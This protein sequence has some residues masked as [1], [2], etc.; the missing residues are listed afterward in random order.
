M[1]ARLAFVSCFC[2]IAV[3]FAV[4]DDS[5]AGQLDGA[6]TTQKT[7]NA[8]KKFSVEELLTNTFPKKTSNDTGLNPCKADVFVDDIAITFPDPKRKLYARYVHQDLEETNKHVLYTENVRKLLEKKKIWKLQEATSVPPHKIRKRAAVTTFKE[9][10]WDHGVIPYEIDDTFSDYRKALAKQAMRHWENNTCLK[11]IERNKTENENYVFFTEKPCG[12]CSFVG[13]RGLGAQA[14]SIGSKCA[15]FGVVVHEIG[16][17]IGYYHEH[18]RPDRDSYVEVYLEN[19]KKEQKVNFEKLSPD[20]V[21]SLGLKYDYDSIMHYARN[22]YSKNSYVDT[23]KP[24]VGPGMQTPEIGQR[25][26]LSQGDIIQTQILYNCPKCGKTFQTKSGS[27]SPPAST[28]NSAE[29]STLC[30]WRI[31]ATPGEKIRLNITS[32]DIMKTPNCSQNY[33]EVRD[34]YWKKSKLL[35]VFC[36]RGEVPNIRSESSR[37]LVTYVAQNGDANRGF[38]AD[39]EVICGGVLH[40]DSE[41]YLESPNYP[42][43][44]HPSQKC[45]W[46]ITV[47]EKYQIAVKF[48]AFDLEH[49]ANCSYDYVAIRDG[50]HPN[51]TLLQHSCGALV[52]DDITSTTNEM[53]ITFISDKSNQ[54]GGFSAKI[55]AEFNECEK[56]DHGCEQ[57]CINTLGSFMCGCEPGF[58][59]HSDKISCVD[60]CGGRFTESSG[61]ITSPSFP[62]LYPINKKC[63]WEIEAP[64]QHKI[65]LNFTHM[66]IEGNNY[67]Y[68]LCEYDYV[69]VSSQ[70]TTGKTKLHGSFCGTKVPKMISSESNF[71]KIAFDSDANVQK[72]GFAAVYFI[73]NDECATRN[74]GCDHDCVNTLGSFQCSC[75]TGFTLSENKRSCIEGDCVHEIFTPPHGSI[76]SPNY[77]KYYPPLKDCVWHIKTMPGH[78]IRLD[79]QYFQLEQH[80][81]CYFDYVQIFDGDSSKSVQMGRFC[82]AMGPHSVM[83]SENHLY[84]TFKSDNNVHKKGFLGAY[85]T[86]CGGLLQ[87][88]LEK[89]QIFSHPKYGNITYGP[90]SSCDW[91][92]LGTTGYNVRL[93]F[94][95]FELENE[96]DCVYDYVEVYD[97]LDSNRVSLGRFCGNQTMQEVTTSSQ[98]GMVIKFR[99]DD[100]IAGKG[101]VFNYE[102]VEKTYSLEEYDS[103]L[104]D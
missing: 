30:E 102:L 56:T 54:R 44:Y 6:N 64:A 48:L 91:Y 12:C 81:E 37:M 85:S 75:R 23:I 87:A 67:E 94:T 43:E 90:K 31:T 86:Q 103:P 101:F 92:L 35:G 59:L 18:T 95:E 51:A 22:T 42:D 29:E 66:D 77:P 83:S 49:H 40:I 53:T 98:D 63:V 84:M 55:I 4:R 11:F 32:M 27:F 15:V 10:L 25:L 60:A 72:T 100:H 76:N 58:E 47:P 9:R 89:R 7:F 21:S 2:G 104:D 28:T 45:T 96:E 69:E 34:G 82:G 14:L 78:R 97:G 41:G 93:S 88:T 39:F 3:Q 13:K 20:Q 24:I 5:P 19:V 79:F 16:H 68:Q 8:H 70:L 71:L 57:L 36:G 17:A 1:L 73:D 33:L 52:P 62:E 99:T 80:Q 26:R 38:T 46:L 74:G 65:F 61:T 50:L